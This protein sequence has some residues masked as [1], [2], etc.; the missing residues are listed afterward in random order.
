MPTWALAG[1]PLVLV[2]LLAMAAAAVAGALWGRQRQQD[3]LRD[4][5]QQTHLLGQ[6]VDLWCWQTDADHRL[7]A[8]QPPPAAPPSNWLA[9]AAG[10]QRL[11]QRFDDAEHSLQARMQAQGP[12][13][14][15]RVL[16]VAAE[17]DAPRA[18][19]LRGL[20]RLDGQ[21]QFAGY[22][23][24]AWPTETDDQAANAWQA[25]TR[26]RQH[27]P[28]ALCLAAPVNGSTDWHLVQASPAARQLLGLPAADTQ[29]AALPWGQ[30]L[31][32]LPGRLR[33]QVLALQPG[34]LAEADGWQARL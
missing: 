16:H 9:A 33:Q 4:A 2:L 11:W 29:A 30:A 20:P 26:P 24:V 18:W 25:L 21:G 32:G 14:T 6:L 1:W 31:A 7:L 27:G 10:G 19:M 28:A 12:L 8:L 34:E 3:R 5:R 15:L 22:T 23:G 17:G 13:G